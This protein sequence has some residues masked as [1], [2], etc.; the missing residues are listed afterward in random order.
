MALLKHH[1]NR[2][3]LHVPETRDEEVRSCWFA[4]DVAQVAPDPVAIAA[5]F[6]VLDPPP[7]KRGSRLLS[8]VSVLSQTMSGTL[9][10]GSSRVPSFSIPTPHPEPPLSR[11][12]AQQPS[13][14]R[15]ESTTGVSQGAAGIEDGRLSSA[16]GFGSTVGSAGT[17]GGFEGTNGAV[18]VELGGREVRG[19]GEGLEAGETAALLGGVESR[20]DRV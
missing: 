2:M 17:M 5:D 13:R 12:S 20:S 4:T 8:A 15:G 19:Q 3:G 18:G 10:T 11:P 1:P 16:G 7:R 14:F 6:P 9:K